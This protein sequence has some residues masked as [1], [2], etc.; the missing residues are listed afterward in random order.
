MARHFDGGRLV[1]ASHNKNKVHEIADLLA[2]YG[3]DVVSAGELNL[4]EP[5]ETGATFAENAIIKA[6]ASATGANLPA[7]ADDS[8]LVVHAIDGRPGIYSARWATPEGDFGPAMEK[9]HALLENQSDRSAHFMCAL[10]LCWPDGHCEVFE[11]RIDGTIVWPPRGTIGFGYD[12]I[13]L[14][15]GRDKTFGETTLE[16][17]HPVSHR[18]RA[19]SQLVAACFA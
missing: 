19:F 7:L 9:V 2:P 3:T 12:P 10:A 8:G 17:K 14:P 11:G 5:E 13:F 15:E 4:P 16:A 18:A 6:Q 1:I